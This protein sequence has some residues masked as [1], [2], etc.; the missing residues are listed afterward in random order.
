M[1][2]EIGHGES[3]ARLTGKQKLTVSYSD[4]SSYV[5]PNVYQTCGGG[6]E[7]RGKKGEGP[8]NLATGKCQG[9]ET[10]GRHGPIPCTATTSNCEFSDGFCLPKGTRP[11]TISGQPGEEY[12]RV[13]M[14]SQN[15]F[16]NGDLDS[17]P[18]G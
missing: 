16:E 17:A 1:E 7:G 12:E 9:S 10:E 4:G 2:Q 15:Q 5:D 8:C 6:M 18:A 3:C 14:C 13:G 11:V